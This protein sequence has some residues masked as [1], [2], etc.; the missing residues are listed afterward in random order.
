[1][2]VYASRPDSA[3]ERPSRWL[4]GFAATEAG[5]GEEATVD[6]AVPARAFAHWDGGSQSWRT[7]PGAFQ[8]EVGRSC[9]DLPLRLTFTAG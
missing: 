6:V 8:L 5:L 7:E 2:Q 3:V 9:A 4:A 1:V